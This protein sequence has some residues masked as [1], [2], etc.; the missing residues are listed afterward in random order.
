MKQV[1]PIKSLDDVKMIYNRLNK[2]N[3]HREAELVMLGCNVALRISDLLKLRFA[4]IK[5]QRLDGQTVGY[6]ELIEKKTAKEKKLTLNKT[7]MGCIDRLRKMY[8][9][10]VYLFQSTGNR[11]KG[12]EPK[13][14][15]RQW[16]SSK[17]IEVKEGLGLDYSL[18][19]HSLR[20]TFGFHAYKRGTDI[21]VLQK[22][23]NHA[24]V[25]DTFKYI[26]ITDERI[27]D[28][29]LNIEIGL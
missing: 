14:V 26:G 2:W 19:T 1:D 15:S 11:S 9:D 28:V 8:P 29:Y 22:L 5:E 7:A 24:S 16:I 17:L 13:P 27:R 3:R 6:V 21:N 25:T 10:S 12:N 4:D 18:N 20:K 23:F